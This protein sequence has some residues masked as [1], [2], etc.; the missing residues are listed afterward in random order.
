M[1]KP[2]ARTETAVDVPQPEQI[3]YADCNS[4]LLRFGLL[5]WKK[6][7]EQKLLGSGDK[8]AITGDN[9]LIPL[10][11]KQVQYLNMKMQGV[12]LK[13]ICTALQITPATPAFWKEKEGAD[14]LYGICVEA[15]DQIQADMAEDITRDEAQTNRKAN[16]ERM[17]Y[18]K[19]WKPEYRDNFAGTGANLVQLNIT[20]GDKPFTVDVT[21]KDAGSD[22]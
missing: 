8:P 14:S 5:K 11:I 12:P 16:L 13:D 7:N 20:I 19:R 9:E 2:K 10:D 22:D 17:F 1:A 15:I 18:I 4:D 21:T 3:D 6:Q